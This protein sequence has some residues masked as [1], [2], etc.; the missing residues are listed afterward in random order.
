MNSRVVLC[1][2]LAVSLWATDVG[3][4]GQS[5]MS[6]VGELLGKVEGLRM[7]RDHCATVTPEDTETTLAYEA[8]EKR[9]SDLLALVKTQR[10]HADK[11]L[12]KQAL[13]NSSAPK[14]TAEFIA[15]LEGRLLAEL[16]ESDVSSQKAMC[17]GYPELISSSET[18]RR[19]EIAAL[20]K[21]VT[22]A[23]QVLSEREAQP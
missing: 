2:F 15:L 5:Y 20:L 22:H 7:L 13:E 12:A 10:E 18:A 17:A 4:A 14:S 16:R 21:V 9:N 3:A 1:F 6:L 8:W 23:D 11:R 19:E